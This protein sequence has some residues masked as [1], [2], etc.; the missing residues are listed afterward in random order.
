MIAAHLIAA[1]VNAAFD[2]HRLLPAL[3]AEEGP[4]IYGKPGLMGLFVR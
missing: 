3:P 2:V 4:A 1:T